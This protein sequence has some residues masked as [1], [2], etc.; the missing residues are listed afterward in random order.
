MTRLVKL[1]TLDRHR[2]LC[3]WTITCISSFHFVQ[4]LSD[5]VASNSY[6]DVCTVVIERSLP[7]GDVNMVAYAPT[8][9]AMIWAHEIL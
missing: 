5:M 9:V 4:I 8:G 3:R 6:D 2:F 7:L 1:F